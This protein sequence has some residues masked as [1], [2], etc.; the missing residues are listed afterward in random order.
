MWQPINWVLMASVVAVPSPE[1]R[2]FRLA[3]KQFHYI[4]A[5]RPGSPEVLLLHG[6]R[7][8][9]ETWREIGTLDRLAEAGYHVVALDLPGFGQS[10]TSPIENENFLSEAMTSLGLESAVIVS[11]SMSGQFTFP[12]L[13]WDRDKVAGFVPVAPT[14]MDAYLEALRKI[15]VPTL[16]VWGEHDDIIPMSRSDELVAVLKGSER[17]FLKGA[18]HPCYLDAPDA[19]HAELLAFLTAVYP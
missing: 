7:F 12:L 15:R 8:S 6:A 18:R 2:T 13:I 9:S 3:D 1:S 5:G 19:F 11:P 10:E 4:E 14:G 17:V 16:V